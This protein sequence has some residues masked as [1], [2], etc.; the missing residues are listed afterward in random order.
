MEIISYIKFTKPGEKEKLEQLF[1]ESN[2]EMELRSKITKTFE[3]NSIDAGLAAK[4]C[5]A[6]FNHK[7]Q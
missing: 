2:S 4:R 3:I 7:K 1:K 5:N 6:M